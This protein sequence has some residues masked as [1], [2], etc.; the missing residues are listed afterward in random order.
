MSFATTSIELIKEEATKELI[1]SYGG[2]S[3]FD[4][5]F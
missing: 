3:L 4:L 2:I 5:E 1:C